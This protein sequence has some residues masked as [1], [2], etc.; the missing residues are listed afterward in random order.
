LAVKL[1]TD[2]LTENGPDVN[3]VVVTLLATMPTATVLFA[4][5]LAWVADATIGPALRLVVVT[6]LAVTVTVFVLFAVMVAPLEV[7]LIG[8]AF[9]TFVLM[10]LDVIVLTLSVEVT[11]ALALML[12]TELFTTKGP[13][14]IVTR[15]AVIVLAFKSVTLN[16]SVLIELD[17]IPTV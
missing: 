2:V 5:T 9:S 11:V 3:S 6:L 4:V 14:L 8:A 17:T 12:T 7:T 16:V 1:A 15:F 10:V 13:V